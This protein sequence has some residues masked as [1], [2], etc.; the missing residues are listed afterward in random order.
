M[1]GL[2]AAIWA[3]VSIARTAPRRERTDPPAPPPVSTFAD[4][5]AAVGLV[6]ASTENI[7]IGTPLSGVVTRVF[8]GAGDTVKRGQPL[9]ELDSSGAPSP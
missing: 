7:S 4:R 5:V 6:E 8:V 1:I 2:L 3:T 9:F